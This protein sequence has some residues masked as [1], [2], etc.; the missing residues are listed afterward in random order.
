MGRTPRTPGSPRSKAGDLLG[1][2]GQLRAKGYSYALIERQLGIPYLQARELAAEFDAKHGRP[3]RVVRTI[4][5]K[6]PGT[7]ATS[8]PVRDLR[9]EAS[10]ILREVEKG[11]KFLITVS[12]RPV[13]ELS[14]VSTGSVFVPRS[15]VESMIR[16]AP[17]DPNFMADVDEA[18]D[19]R[20]EDR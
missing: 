11:R 18:L 7:G 5:A 20:I 15:V 2:A 6:V 8:I 17:L 12:G 1:K 16:E 19:Q 4:A 9:N 14:P 10:R 13:A 3:K